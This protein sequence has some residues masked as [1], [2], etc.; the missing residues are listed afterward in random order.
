MKT[1]LRT[2]SWRA[3]SSL[4]P[5]RRPN[6]AGATKKSKST[7]SASRPSKVMADIKPT[8]EEISAYFAKNKGFFN[9]PET[10]DL[11]I[12]VA[13][14]AKV[15]DTIQMTDAQIQDYYN[16]HKDEYRTPER[17]HARHILLSTAN[18]PKD[19]V[20]KIQA[21]AEALLK[22][23]KSR[24]GFRRA[25][26]EEL[27]GPRLGPERRR[28]GLGFARPDGQELRRC[29]FHAEAERNQQCGHHRIWL[30]HHSGAGEA[31]GPPANAG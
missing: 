3:S 29:G 11:Q 2:S 18:K 16:A 31:A 22:Q 10:R 8:P 28:P 9:V 24:R 23:I 30:P 4:P 21:Q 13:D 19:E 12:I 15:A 14:Q 5:K 20:P 27:P 6:I 25:C 1:R 17:V 7:T 26:Q